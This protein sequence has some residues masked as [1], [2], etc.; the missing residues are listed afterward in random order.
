MVVVW[1]GTKAAGYWVGG[2]PAAEAGRSHDRHIQTA[3]FVSFPAR[4]P[5]TD[6]RMNLRVPAEHV[7]PDLFADW[8]RWG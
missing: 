8:K 6:P 2:V 5:R 1:S 3:V 4:K 7:A